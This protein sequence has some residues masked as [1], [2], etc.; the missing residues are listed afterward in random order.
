MKSPLHRTFAS[1][2][3]AHSMPIVGVACVALALFLFSC[4]SIA[5]A[6][7]ATPVGD[8]GG[9]HSRYSIVC[10]IHGD[11][12]YLYHDTRGDEHR[13]DEV[14]L[15]KAKTVAER[16][17]QA[18]VFIFHE[19]R[20]THRL[21]LFPR[22]DG[23]FY[24]YRHGRLIAQESYWRDQGQLRFDP[25]MRIYN[26]FRAEESPEPVSLFLYF[27]HEIPEFGGAGYDA[28][29]KRRTFTV[30]DLAGGL[31]CITRDSTKVDLVVLSTCFSGTPRT[32]AT[33][34]PYA[35][36]IVASPDNLHLSYFDLSA[37]ERLDAGLEAGDV[38]GFANTFAHHA[39]DRLAQDIQT[40]VTV[41]VFDAD[42]V[43]DYLDSV[44][45]TYD[46][47]LTT[48]KGKPSAA[49]EHCDCGE[50]PSYTLPAMNEGVTVLYRPARFGRLSHKESHSGWECWK[51]VN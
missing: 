17:T 11:G 20:R 9:T 45:S 5:P 24:Y 44:D 15:A 41:V 14:T 1:A 28:S 7:R 32:I 46:H 38:S 39:F 3:Q 12:D 6:H 33:L 8:E 34:A 35:R 47:A 2:S 4:S 36:Y 29:Y 13:A 19:R 25:E 49:T 21:L 10:I 42:R 51:L 40:A 26:R 27:G 31:K 18:E 50:D 48:V 22:R 37:L 16:N 43:G 23:T 30:D